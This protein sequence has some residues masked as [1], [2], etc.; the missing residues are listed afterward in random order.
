MR[1][2]GWAQVQCDWCPGKK[3]LI[4]RETVRMEVEN[5]LVQL[6]A[7]GCQELAATLPIPSSWKRLRGFSPE[8]QR[9]CGPFQCLELGLVT[10]RTVRE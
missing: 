9:E 5:G 1:S 2:L 3:R 6:P 7:K 4:H 8:S 10:S